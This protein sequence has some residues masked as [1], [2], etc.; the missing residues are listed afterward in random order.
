MFFSSSVVFFN[1]IRS[2]VRKF[3]NVIKNDIFDPVPAS[4]L[5]TLKS[6]VF[7]NSIEFETSS[8]TIRTFKFDGFK[9]KLINNKGFSKINL[10]SYDDKLLMYTCKH[11]VFEIELLNFQNI[12]AKFPNIIFQL[13]LMTTQSI[14][15]AII[16]DCCGGSLS[17]FQ[18]F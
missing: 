16:V 14:D 3:Y 2:T 7:K 4:H 5:H 15:N 18:R 1:L 6:R 9:A 17:I 8:S 11:D 10:F 13:E 12:F